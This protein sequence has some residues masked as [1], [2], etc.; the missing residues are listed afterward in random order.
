MSSETA[1]PGTPALSGPGARGVSRYSLP[2]VSLAAFWLG[3]I[4][5]GVSLSGGVLAGAQARQPST[6]LV[7]VVIALFVVCLVVIPTMRLAVSVTIDDQRI[8]THT[9]IGRSQ[10]TSWRHVKSIEST[11]QQFPWQSPPKIVITTDAGRVIK[12]SG[13]MQDF[14][15]LVADLKQRYE[16]NRPDK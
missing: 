16:I 7:S 11:S 10:T 1:T 3:T 2:G 15:S 12:L 4:A 14:D 5:A 13:K 9:I 6:L 8:T